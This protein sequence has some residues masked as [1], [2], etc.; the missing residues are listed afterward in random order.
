MFVVFISTKGVIGGKAPYRILKKYQMRFSLV[1]FGRVGLPNKRAA[2]M[3]LNAPS[4][5]SF[6]IN[7][8]RSIKKHVILALTRN[9]WDVDIFVQ[10]WN[11]DLASHMN[12]F[13]KPN[14]S[15]HANQTHYVSICKTGNASRLYL[16]ERTSA[17]MQR[18]VVA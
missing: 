10:S 9:M 11:M 7:S 1:L 14:S 5:V 18:V 13:W 8:A 6:W 3:R 15:F 4:S 2:D 12:D 16:C 17:S